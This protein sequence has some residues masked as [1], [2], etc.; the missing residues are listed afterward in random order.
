MRQV[1]V[2]GGLAIAICFLCENKSLSIQGTSFVMI[3][4]RTESCVSKARS[5]WQRSRASGKSGHGSW[6]RN[7][8]PHMQ[9]GPWQS[10]SNC[11][12]EKTCMRFDPYLWRDFQLITHLQIQS[13]A[14]KLELA[15]YM[16]SSFYVNWLS[17]VCTCTCNC[18]SW[19]QDLAG[20]ISS[21]WFGW[22]LLLRAFNA[23]WLKAYQTFYTTSLKHLS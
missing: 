15:V 3:L 19:S 11:V 10:Q 18:Q 4:Q 8:E 1:H 17:V 2:G 13:L 9:R 14:Q 7:F 16:L 20:L 12:C 5:L 22:S 21:S 6:S 23:F